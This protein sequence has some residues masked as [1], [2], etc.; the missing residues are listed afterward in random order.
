MVENFVFQFHLQCSHIN[1]L[2][3][4]I[5]PALVT[6]N[7]DG[8][9]SGTKRGIRNPLMSKQLENKF[10]KNSRNKILSKFLKRGLHLED[11]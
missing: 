5:P 1:L 8:D 6:K 9:I 11:F 10:Y 2:E 4:E 7:H 3:Y